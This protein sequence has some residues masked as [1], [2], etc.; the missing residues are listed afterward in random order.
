MFR[1]P[2]RQELGGDQA[3]GTEDASRTDAAPGTNEALRLA[4]PR[5]PALAL[6]AFVLAALTLLGAAIGRVQSFVP[7][8]VAGFLALTVAL[9]ALERRPGLHRSVTSGL[10]PL[11]RVLL[12]HMGLLFVPAGVA[13]VQGL[14]ALPARDALPVVLALAVSTLLGMAVAALVMGRR[15]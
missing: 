15:R 14:L 8:A 2:A 3:P 11:A 1:R 10:V 4:S 12:G 7:G 9:A 6:A 13:G 5:L